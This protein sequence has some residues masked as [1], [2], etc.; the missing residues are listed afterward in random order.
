MTQSI[1]FKVFTIWL[2]ILL[3]AIVNGTVRETFFIPMLSSNT[4]LMLSGVTL[5]LAIMFVTYATLPWIGQRQTTTYLLIG[6]SWLSMTLVFEFIFGRIQGQSWPQL[7]E[8]YLFKEGNIWPIV[9]LTT[10]FSPY[11]SA[12]IRGWV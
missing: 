10:T 5:A 2:S 8:A 12:K 7:F 4:G 3:L 9:L 11:F 1:T 6:F